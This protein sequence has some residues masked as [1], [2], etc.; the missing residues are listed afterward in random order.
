[1]AKLQEIILEPD[2]RANQPAANTVAV[3]AIYCVTDEENILERSNGATWDLFSPSGAPAGV[4]LADGSVPMAADL[5][6]DGNQ[7]DNVGAPGAGDHAANK[8]YVDGAIAA[9]GG[10]TSFEP[11]VIVTDEAQAS[12]VAPAYGDVATPGPSV[13]ITS[14]GAVA[15]VRYSAKIRRPG[16]GGG[17]TGW[18]SVDVS[19]A[20][21][22]PASNTNGAS[23]VGSAEQTIGRTV[24]L[25]ITPGTNTYKL[26]YSNDGGGTWNFRDRLIEVFAP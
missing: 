2:T 7:I 6:M 25:T 4:I 14:A 16:G 13:T 22:I 17:F 26:Q 10:V 9:A 1:M 20:T 21:T 12:G 8:T 18:A 11:G 3:G 23:G 15:V 5:D 24:F 19:G